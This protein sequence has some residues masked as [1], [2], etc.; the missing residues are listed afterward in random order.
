MTETTQRL[1]LNSP[2]ANSSSSRLSAFGDED[3]QSLGGGVW[4]EPGSRNDENSIS[5]GKDQGHLSTGFDSNGVD[6]RFVAGSYPESR[7]NGKGYASGAV[8]RSQ[9]NMPPLFT[10]KK[11]SKFAKVPVSLSVF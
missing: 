5:K 10:Q 6:R 11:V 3:L 4:V 7:S 9:S 1:N 8:D 2:Y